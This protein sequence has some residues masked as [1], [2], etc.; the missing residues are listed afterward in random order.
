MNEPIPC[1]PT[2]KLYQAIMA[3]AII[4]FFGVTLLGLLNDIDNQKSESKET[5][6][7][8]KILDTQ[9]TKDIRVETIIRVYQLKSAGRPRNI[10][11][12][13]PKQSY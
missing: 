6:I 11:K 13:T 9:I 8:Y 4:L 10:G 2:I 1:P 7:D 5:A 12:R 3:A